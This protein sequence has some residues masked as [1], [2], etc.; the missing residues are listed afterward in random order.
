MYALVTTEAI[1]MLLKGGFDRIAV[2]L[3][4]LQARQDQAGYS[5]FEEREY[6]MHEGLQG[7]ARNP[8]FG[9]GVEAFRAD[10]GITSHST[11]VDL[12]YN[13]GLVGFC[14]FYALFV[15][16]LYRLFRA[17]RM[18]ARTL[19]A[20]VLATVVCYVFVSLSGTMFYHPYLAIF[21]AAA[22]ALLHRFDAG[23]RPV[24]SNARREASRLNC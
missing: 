12:L 14:L 3:D 13:T 17:R 24:A 4:V 19:H 6:W 16:L 5:G 11:P 18:P 1:T 23:S 2:G 21:V 8:L 20:L 9:H 15:L 7:W 22:A 10:Y